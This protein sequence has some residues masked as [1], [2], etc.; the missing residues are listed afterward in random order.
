M[1][2]KILV[3]GKEINF[4]FDKETEG[5]R[6]PRE[7]IDD[8]EYKALLYDKVVIDIGANLCTFSLWIYDYAKVIYAIEPHQENFNNFVKTVETN[9]LTRI[10]PFHLAISRSNGV[11]KLKEAGDCGG[12]HLHA[13]G[14][15]EVETITLN[16]FLNKNGIEFADVVKID[17]EG[18]EKEIFSVSDFPEASSRLPYIIGEIHSEICPI[19]EKAGYY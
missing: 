18:E 9:N 17:V 11:G 14:T 1:N 6:Y 16:T 5:T 3:R 8:E 7:I 15:E 4:Y 13:E 2:R 19:L 12:W 10:K